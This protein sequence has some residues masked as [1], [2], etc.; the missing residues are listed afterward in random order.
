MWLFWGGREVGKVCCYEKGD[1]GAL[2]VYVA[3]DVR[4]RG[5]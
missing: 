1:D 5:L 3:G 4:M 2:N